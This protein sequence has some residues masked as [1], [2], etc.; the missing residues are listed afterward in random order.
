MLDKNY[1]IN[2]KPLRPKQMKLLEYLLMGTDDVTA[3]IKSGY[4]KNSK[5]IIIRLKPL[6]NQ[7]MQEKKNK[8]KEENLSKTECIKILVKL[9][10]N[11]SNPRVQIQAIQQISK[12]SGYE[13]IKTENANVNEVH[14]KFVEDEKPEPEEIVIKEPIIKEP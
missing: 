8:I 14:V 12:M 1:D 7:M 13:I 4:S 11:E 9:A 6:V 5:A 10:L 3:L 2:L